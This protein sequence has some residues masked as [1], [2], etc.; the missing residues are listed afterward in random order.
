[1]II[2]TA[3]VNMIENNLRNG[4]GQVFDNMDC[5]VIFDVFEIVNKSL[6]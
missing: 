1:M 4:K 3:A 6:K 2:F 5:N